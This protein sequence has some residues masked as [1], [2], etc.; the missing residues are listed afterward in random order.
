V[1]KGIE[2]RRMI[3]K[4]YGETKLVNRCKNGVKCSEEEHLKNRRTEFRII[5]GPETIEIS[6]QKPAGS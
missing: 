1:E 3:A 5:S 4:G 6:E 2:P